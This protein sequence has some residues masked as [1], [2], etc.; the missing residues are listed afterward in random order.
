MRTLIATPVLALL[1]LGG[2][3][4]PQYLVSEQTSAVPVAGTH[5][6]ALHVD[7]RFSATQR[8][9]IIAGVGDWNRTQSGTVGFDVDDVKEGRAQPGSWTIT[10][11]SGL[12]LAQ[13]DEWRPEPLAVTRRFAG[14]GGSI[15]VFPNRLG[16]HNLRSVV[17][18]ELGSALGAR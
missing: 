10:Q 12:E 6:M 2:C 9:E 18:S 1:L 14:G 17:A 5:R 3:A 16:S 7:D 13:S 4:Q 11:P 8:N 15:E